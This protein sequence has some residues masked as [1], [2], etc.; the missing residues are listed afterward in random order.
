MKNTSI[1]G[2]SSWLTDAPLTDEQMA[3]GLKSIDNEMKDPVRRFQMTRGGQR[4][5][6]ETERAIEKDIYRRMRQLTNRN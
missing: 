4:L 3:D 6:D 1:H 5:V 2:K